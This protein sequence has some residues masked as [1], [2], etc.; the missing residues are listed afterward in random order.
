MIVN[1]NL[2]LLKEVSNDRLTLLRNGY[3]LGQ[4]VP[5]KVGPDGIELAVQV[6]NGTDGHGVPTGFDA[7]RLVWVHVAIKD[8]TGK[9]IHESG[10]LD[11]DG[12]VRDLR[13]SYV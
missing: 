5:R 4:I 13:S 7:E 3:K 2:A 1:D 11:P 8:G 10:D 6:K 12:D 9:T